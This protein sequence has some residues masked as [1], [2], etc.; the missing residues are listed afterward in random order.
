MTKRYFTFNKS[1]FLMRASFLIALMF[2][3][4][5]FFNSNIF[6]DIEHNG[7]SSYE[8]TDQDWNGDGVLDGVDKNGGVVGDKL[9]TWS[10]AAGIH[11]VGTFDVEKG[12]TLTIEPGAIIKFG[13][14]AESNI[15]VHGTLIA[16]GS[17][18]NKIVFTSIN[19]DS[20]GGDTNNDGNT[21][22]PAP[23]SWGSINFLENSVNCIL[24][25]TVIL[26][27]AGSYWHWGNLYNINQA[28]LINN[29]NPIISNNI[30]QHGNHHGIYLANSSAEIT[31]N[32]IS[33]FAWSGI[34]SEKVE[35]NISD[36]TITDCGGSA[37]AMEDYSDKSYTVLPSFSN[38]TFSNNGINGISFQ[39]GTIKQNL[40]LEAIKNPYVFNNM[41]IDSGI[42]LTIKPGVIV[43]FNIHGWWE[44]SAL[45]VHGTLIADGTPEGKI[46]FTSINDDTY[47]G[48]TNNDKDLTVGAVYD[49]GSIVF[50]EDSKNSILDNNII[51]YAGTEHWGYYYSH[52]AIFIGQ[53]NPTI[54]NNIIK[55]GGY[56][57]IY[58]ANSSAEITGNT[59]SDFAWSGISSEKVEA[60]I[61]DNTITDCGGSAIAMEDY[62][63]KSYTVLPSFSNNTFS[64]NGI[65]GISFQTGTIK[66]NLTLEAIKNPYVFNN[67]TIDSGIVLTIKP[68]VIV[69]FNIHGWWEASALYVHGTLIADGTPEG[70]IVFT[71]I[72]DD[73]Y[74]GDTNNDKDLTVGAVY[75]WGS[76]VFYEDSKNS[77]LDNNIIQYAGTE[78]WGYYYSHYAIF[79]GQSNPTISNNIIK[80]G[81]YDGIYLANSSAEITGNT[82]SDF[83][84]SG[85]SMSDT[86][87]PIINYNT[88]SSNYEGIHTTGY[89]NPSVNN[90]NIIEN[91]NYGL[92]NVDASIMVNAVNN[93][94][95]DASG[96]NDPTDGNPDYN[97]NGTGDKVSDYINYRPWL[98]QIITSVDNEGSDVNNLPRKYSLSQN[99]PNPFNPST[100]INYSLPKA[101]HVTL[102]VFDILGR[103]V[104]ELVNSK[105]NAGNYSVQFSAAGEA[106]NLS[107]GIYLYKLETGNFMSVK[108]MI[109]LK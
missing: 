74:G 101:G 89:S 102:R 33:D 70:K 11:I 105:Q 99:Y 93:W 62:S 50:Y 41:T 48:D 87:A 90:N 22:S 91:I 5:P 24:D 81:G 59:I 52:Y 75:D 66:Q 2:F 86:S 72:N 80:H 8:D 92:N 77:I 19:D 57:G 28:V 82:I 65:N 36:N 32:T 43:K 76:I 21:T 54:S 53:S 47:G 38:N 103:K 107:S 67:M 104:A 96:P 83:A 58:L 17:V 27:A 69:K 23:G 29:S 46:V 13:F 45:Y 109:V 49:W 9:L 3:L 7:S 79:I 97:P 98:E 39:T 56:D 85:I 15:S 25:N 16:D 51:Q 20:Y 6:A 106:S 35:A 26:Y 12:Y 63:D 10:V 60:N 40:T 30:I 18:N 64:N 61:S 71:S 34:S 4:T 37:I 78:H 94:W 55:H 68:G 88:I 31:G 84:W 73:T 44:A 1:K 100:T 95:G 14:S 42:V 108:K